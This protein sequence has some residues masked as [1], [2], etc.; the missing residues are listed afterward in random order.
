M[1]QI[2]FNTEVYTGTV[3]CRTKVRFSKYVFRVR[4]ND[5]RL[6]SPDY[7]L[8]ASANNIINVVITYKHE[9]LSTVLS[10][11]QNRYLLLR[12]SKENFNKILTDVKCPMITLG[13]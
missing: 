3:N 6:Q 13:L 2:K 11:W 9:E 5:N 7:G 10:N 12:N 1:G 4:S 8:L